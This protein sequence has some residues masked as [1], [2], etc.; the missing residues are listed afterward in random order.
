MEYSLFEKSLLLYEAPGD[1]PPDMPA[2]DAGGATVPDS[3]P[4]LETPDDTGPPDLQEPVGGDDPIGEAPPDD[5]G[6]DD[7]FG[8]GGGFDEPEG[9]DDQQQGQELQL[10]D[11]VS[12]ILNMNL[13]QSFLSLLNTIGNQIALISSNSDTLY[14]LSKD[15]SDTMGVL[16]KLDE[17]IRLYLNNY[18]EIENYSNNLLFYHKC[19][20]LLNISK[21]IFAKSTKKGISM[22]DNN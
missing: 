21:E 9:G 18:F 11:K 8:G 10:D 14:I 19:I 1:P 16:K 3:P 17:N 4:D 15:I 13:Y 7:E 2:D 22:I 20:N 12:S 6:G 5:F